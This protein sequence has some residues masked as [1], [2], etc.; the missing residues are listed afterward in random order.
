MRAAVLLALATAA[1]G[2]RTS[3]DV[4]RVEEAFDASIDHAADGAPDALADAAVDAPMCKPKSRCTTANCPNGCCAGDTCVSGTEA[5]KCGTHGEA[6]ADCVA[7]GYTQ[8]DSARRVCLKPVRSCNE[9]TAFAC[10]SA[11]GGGTQCILTGYAGACESSACEQCGAG[12]VCQG[13]CVAPC[14]IDT[15]PSGCCHNGACVSGNDDTLCGGFGESCRDCTRQP[16]DRCV[17]HVC[18]T[19][20]AKCDASTCPSGCCATVN[21]R[22][23][24]LDG[25][26][27]RACGFG[28]AACNDCVAMGM[29]CDIATHACKQPECAQ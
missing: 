26:S 20:V 16:N 2:A 18:T 12:Q 8:C 11:A 7:L 9:C 10:C 27:A 13:I 3:I 6:C 14:G 19:A 1:C 4:A 15:C 21:G 29:T 23:S 5:A 25:I 24:C 22:I 28:A 17:D